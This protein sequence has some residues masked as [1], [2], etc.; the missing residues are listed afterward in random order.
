M[1]IRKNVSYWPEKET[2]CR[3]PEVLTVTGPENRRASL[4]TRD[5]S[6]QTEAIN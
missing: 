6:E 1:G 4:S 3:G 5:S 2:S